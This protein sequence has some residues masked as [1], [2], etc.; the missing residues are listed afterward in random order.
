MSRYGFG[1]I[2]E[3]AYTTF[4]VPAVLETG[5]CEM[6]FHGFFAVLLESS[7]PG[8]DIRACGE[9]GKHGAVDVDL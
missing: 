7:V 4:P 8:R 6:R 1:Q 5:V 9:E 2:P 3:Q